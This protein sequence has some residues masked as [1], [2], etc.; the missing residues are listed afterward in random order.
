PTRS[1][2]TPALYVHQAVQFEPV[3]GEPITFTTV[4]GGAYRV[5]QVVPVLYD[6]TDP[7]RAVI[8]AVRN[9]WVGPGLAVAGG[10]GIL[11]LSLWGHPLAMGA[12]VFLSLVAAALNPRIITAI[13]R[14]V[15]ALTIS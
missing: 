13:G 6:P 9:L 14:V 15:V 5:G 10:A 2:W 11:L 1:G 7:R 12:V 4:S 8:N 3:A